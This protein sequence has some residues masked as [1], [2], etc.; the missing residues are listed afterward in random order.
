MNR[1]I[2]AVLFWGGLWGISEA[3]IGYLAHILLP[4]MGWL[5]YYPA[6]Y[7]FL[8]GAYRQTGKLPVVLSCA[9]LSAAIKLI[10]LPMMP[11]L[12]YV[13][14][15][16][17]SILL[18]GLTAGLAF[19]WAC[20]KNRPV[21]RYGL[22]PFGTSAVWR[23]LYLLYLLLAPGWIREVSVLQQPGKLAHFATLE[24]LGNGLVIA[25]GAMG[26]RLLV[27][28]KKTPLARRLKNGQGLFNRFV[29]ALSL[30]AVCLAVALQWLL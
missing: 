9:I 6:A 7:A 1:N 15:P 18:E 14:N 2:S 26:A 27:K 5:F 30:A 4:G 21:I 3:T 17:V 28:S 29:N 8:L 16:A 20:K 12:D 19:R 23:G 22:L 13:I 24:V 11:R 10:N 25:L